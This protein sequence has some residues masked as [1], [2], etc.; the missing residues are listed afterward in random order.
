MLFKYFFIIFVS[1]KHLQIMSLV[2]I[3]I[4]DDG[5]NWEKQIR[6]C[7][8]L[9]YHRHDYTKHNNVSRPIGF[10]SGQYCSGEVREE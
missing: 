5:S 4:N 6:I 3:R 9:V 1:A 8:I 2:S 10:T 7:G